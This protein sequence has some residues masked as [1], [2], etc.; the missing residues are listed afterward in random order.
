MAEKRNTC[1]IFVGMPEG[2]KLIGRPRRRWENNIKTDCKEIE[3]YGVDWIDLA[4][5]KDKWRTL[6]NTVM[7]LQVP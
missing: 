1:R 7:K 5:E 6:L 2:K 4:Q 3:W